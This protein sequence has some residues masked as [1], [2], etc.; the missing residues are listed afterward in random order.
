MGKIKE[1]LLNNLTP[2]QIDEFMEDTAFQ[3]V[4]YMSPE[5][6]EETIDDINESI[7]TKYSDAD[8]QEAINKVSDG[9]SHTQKVF[10]LFLSELNQSY[11]S[12]MGYE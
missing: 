1:N 5:L 9:T 6:D 3:F 4:E 2:E 7:K 12:K 10:E 11:L 8:I